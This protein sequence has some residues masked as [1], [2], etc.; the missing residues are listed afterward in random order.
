V[1]GQKSRV[2]DA[3]ARCREAGLEVSLFINPDLDQV[4]ASIEVGASAVELHTGQFADA[5]N[6]AEARGELALLVQASV[7]VR[8]A[9]MKLHAGHGLNY[10]NVAE[11]ARIE[12]MAELNIGHS[13]ISRAIFCGLREAV[14]AMKA[15]IHLDKNHWLE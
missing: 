9:G 11:V 1:L 7:A 5:R 10:W 4:A 2:A 14:G 12:G 3:V 13:I 15:A 8:R 6:S